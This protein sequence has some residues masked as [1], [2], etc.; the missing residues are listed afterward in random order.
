MWQTVNWALYGV[1]IAVSIGGCIFMAIKLPEVLPI[2]L[3]YVFIIDG[4]VFLEYAYAYLHLF[5]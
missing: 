3:I 5:G 4:L 2:Y 1:L